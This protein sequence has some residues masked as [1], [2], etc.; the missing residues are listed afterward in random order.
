PMDASKRPALSARRSG[1][2]LAVTSAATG[3]GKSTHALAFA[4]PAALA[5]EKV[6]LVDADLRRSGVS[7]L[8]AQS[9]CFTLR[10]FL[11]SRCTAD[12]VITLEDRSGVH[13]VPSNPVQAT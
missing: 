2:A 6:V 8:L 3:E 7:R 11:Q 4:R 5:G 1:V 13:F 10:D 9:H 12:E